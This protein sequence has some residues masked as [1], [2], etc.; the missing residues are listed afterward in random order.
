MPLQDICEK[1]SGEIL[2]LLLP[3]MV[4]AQFSEALSFV[5]GSVSFLDN[6]ELYLS[7][8][9]HRFYGSTLLPARWWT[10][11]D[12]VETVSNWKELTGLSPDVVIMPAS[13]FSR[14][15]CDL[16]GGTILQ[17]EQQLDVEFCRIPMSSVV[18]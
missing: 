17:L 2:L 16:L 4:F 1:H 7:D 11:S 14:G 10:V 5:S 12:I 18:T 3:G 13:A 15:G 8:V 9:E 6:V